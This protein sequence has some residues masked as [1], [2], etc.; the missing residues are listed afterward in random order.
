VYNRALESSITWRRWKCTVQVKACAYSELEAVSLKL[1]ILYPWLNQDQ[2]MEDPAVI[3][4]LLCDWWFVPK[5]PLLVQKASSKLRLEINQYISDGNIP[6]WFL[7]A[8]AY[9]ESIEG[10]AIAAHRLCKPTTHLL[11]L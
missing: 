9:L 1:Q 10:D 7:K 5:E 6:N 11:G 8:C 3:F 4:A 2:D